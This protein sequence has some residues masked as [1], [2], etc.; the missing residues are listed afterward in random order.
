MLPCDT[1]KH[2][3]Y[4]EYVSSHSF[5]IPARHLW[6]LHALSLCDLT[7]VRFMMFFTYSISLGR[8]AWPPEDIFRS[9]LAMVLCG[10]TAFEVWVTKMREEPFYAII[11]GFHPESVPGVGTFY[12]FA[13]RIV[14][15]TNISKRRLRVKWRTARDKQKSTKDK[16]ADTRKH[17]DI[18]RRLVARISRVTRKSSPQWEF[19]DS[20]Y[21]R[22][23]L[24]L[25]AIFYVCFVA[26]SI[27]KGIID[28][29]NLFVAGDGTKLKTWSNSHGKKVCSCQDRCDCKR[30]FTDFH[31]RW[32]YD[33]YR[34]CY[35][36][37]HSKYELTAYS[38]NHKIQVPLVIR[39]A[40]CNR[41]DLI[42]GISA[43]REACEWLNFPVKV[44]TFDAAHDAFAFYQLGFER[45]SIAQVIPI[46][47]KNTGNFTYPQPTYKEDG[48]PICINNMEMYYW[49][50]CKDRMRL[51]WRCP[52]ICTKSSDDIKTCSVRKQCSK[53]SYGRVVF[54]Y[55]KTN[56]R[57]FT[58]IPRNTELFKKHYKH[59]SCAER[60]VKRQKFDFALNQTKTAG[61][62][63]WFLRVML[64]AMAQHV[65]AWWMIEEGKQSIKKAA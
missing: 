26:K 22:Y 25:K 49:G 41:H 11:S 7:I 35:V 50:Y 51:K 21:A 18:A 53:S 30:Q 44:G 8:P 43:L 56:Y 17:A 13:D 37:G 58:V 14:G 55:P 64:A 2:K 65:A 60:S 28:L 42:L 52:L 48:T 24:V 9:M 1:R 31:A 29:E 47:P 45:Y 20:K 34:E 46:N 57:L 39:M 33:S 63:R 4:V 54:T 10:I 62:E 59:R 40:D 3:E 36:Y 27:E 5:A 38:F 12:D 61:R 15:I 19:D 32:G 23:E 6:V 16:N